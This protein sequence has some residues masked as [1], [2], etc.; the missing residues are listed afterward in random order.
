MKWRVSLGTVLLIV[1]LGMLEPGAS[2]VYWSIKDSGLGV[3][4]S[5]F[6]I[7]LILAAGGGG[8]LV[9]VAWLLFGRRIR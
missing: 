1:A 6:P 9:G 7:S 8:L 3:D 2:V 4:L 5:G